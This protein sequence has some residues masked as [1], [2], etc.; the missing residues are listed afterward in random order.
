[1]RREE[2]G[3]EKLAHLFSGDGK[4]EILRPHRQ[5]GKVHEKEKISEIVSF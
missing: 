4:C 3:G 1:M 2:R 5:A